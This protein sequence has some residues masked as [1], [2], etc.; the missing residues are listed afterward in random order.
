MKKNF[1]IKN[2]ETGLRKRTLG[3]Q[4]SGASSRRSDRPSLMALLLQ[5]AERPPGPRAP[6]VASLQIPPLER[7]HPG[8]QPGGYSLRGLWLHPKAL[9]GNPGDRISF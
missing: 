5:L 4:G 9:P 3:A 6:L 7:Q 8:D 1:K 2:T